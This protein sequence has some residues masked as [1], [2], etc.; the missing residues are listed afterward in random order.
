VRRRAQALQ[1]ENDHLRLRI[2]DLE[3]GTRR[4]ERA[5]AREASRVAVSSPAP[6]R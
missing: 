1:R 3:A 4:A 2:A 6:G 5:D